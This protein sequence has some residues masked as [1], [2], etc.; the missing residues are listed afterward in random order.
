[1]GSKTG[2]ITQIT[3]SRSLIFDHSITGSLN[4]DKWVGGIKYKMNV[5]TV[6]MVKG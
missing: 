3:I 6:L 4:L 5:A 2:N 1:M